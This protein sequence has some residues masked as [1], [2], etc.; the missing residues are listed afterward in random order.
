MWFNNNFNYFRILIIKLI[1]CLVTVRWRWHFKNVK[2]VPILQYYFF[3]DRD[4]SIAL[5]ISN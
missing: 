3:F 5:F 1:V 4:I 2:M